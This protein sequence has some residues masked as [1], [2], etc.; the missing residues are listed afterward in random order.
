VPFDG[1]WLPGLHDVVTLYVVGSCDGRVARR[2]QTESLSMVWDDPLNVVKHL[3][4]LVSNLRAN[5][6]NLCGVSRACAW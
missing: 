5:K 6:I 3:A 2:M 1:L 4:N